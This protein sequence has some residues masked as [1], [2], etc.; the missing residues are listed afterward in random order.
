MTCIRNKYTLATTPEQGSETDSLMINN[1][2]TTLAD[3]AIAVA[4]R[5]LQDKQEGER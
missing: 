3:I 2:L 4:S 1:F 5:N